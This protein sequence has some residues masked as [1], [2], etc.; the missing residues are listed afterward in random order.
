LNGEFELRIKEL[1][2]IQ[3]QRTK[4]M[5]SVFLI[6][7]FLCTAFVGMAQN[8]L[9]LKQAI[10]LGIKNNINVAQ[11]DLLMQKAGITLNQSRQNVLPNLN[12][13]ANEGVNYGRSI[14]PFTNAFIDQKVGYANYGASSNVLLFNGFSLHNEIKSN[15]TGYEASKMELQQAKD[16]LTIN[17][18]LAYLQVLS[19]EDVLQ[20]SQEQ[21]LVT[22]KQ[23]DRL[24]V[25][26]QSGAILPS[27]YYDL[28]GQLANDQITIVD[29]KANLETMKLNLAQLLNI[30]YDKNLEV[31]RMPEA[32]FNVNYTGT[33]DSIYQTALQQF[34]QVKATKL[35]TESAEQNI[36]SVKG[37]LFPTLTF[38]GNINTN[39]SSV[40]TRDYF[41]NTTENPSSNYVTVNGLQYPVIVKQDNYQ[42]KKINYGDQLNNNLFYTIN[43]GLTVPLFN[44]SRI[45][46]QIKLAKL[47][48]KNYEL[49]EQNTKTQLQQLIERAYVNLT[50]SSDKYKL[51]QSQVAS[52]EESFRTAEIRFNAGAI[53]SVDYL[54]AKNNLNRAQSNL[55]IAK[56]DFV[57]REKVLDYYGGKSLW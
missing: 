28:K 42:A 3:K 13:N 25:L 50:S 24:G 15:K 47:D 2:Q 52:F 49:V 10:E 39:Y 55:I 40:A 57:L 35:R 29:N 31:E 30:P 37:Q 14:D 16:N 41:I 9:S 12:A 45:R 18:I 23:V 43:L 48:L 56:Y 51:L 20:Q 26:N 36:R 6:G 5:K 46:N 11:S 8:K 38:G 22:Q 33:P 17:I 19:A 1:N 44:A 34:A 54:I 27:D 7:A 21:V 53:T 4:N 32:N